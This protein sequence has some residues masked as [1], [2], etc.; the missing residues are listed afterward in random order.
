MQLFLKQKQK[1]FSVKLWK[2]YCIDYNDR[3]KQ[4]EQLDKKDLCKLQRNAV[5]QLLLS[6]LVTT[7][8]ML[9]VK[10]VNFTFGNR[11]CVAFDT[12]TKAGMQ[13]GLI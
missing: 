4:I 5:T 2:H 7:S 3:L 1:T 11:Y 13:E 10:I 8:S 12:D 9:I 6:E